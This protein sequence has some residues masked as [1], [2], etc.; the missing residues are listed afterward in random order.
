MAV[1]SAQLTAYLALETAMLAL[2]EDPLAHSLADDLRDA[3]DPVW[4]SLAPEEKAWLNER[5]IGETH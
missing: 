3:M 5:R 1:F 4:H 2:D